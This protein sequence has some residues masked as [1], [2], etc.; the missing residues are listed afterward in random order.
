MQ[1]KSDELAAVSP[2]RAERLLAGI[3][4]V[5]LFTMAV[6]VAINVVS[7]WLWSALIPDDIILIQEFMVI[8]ILFPL[9]VVTAAREHIQVDVFTLWLPRRIQ[10]G[11]SVLEQCVGLAFIA[12]LAWAAWRGLMDA[13]RT[14]DYYSGTLDVPMWLGHTSFFVGISF[15]LFRLVLMLFRDLRKLF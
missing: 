14:Q 3:S 8:V 2:S 11:L 4:V 7:R 9:G 12:V 1:Q 10:N 6:I 5:G 13:W 15:F